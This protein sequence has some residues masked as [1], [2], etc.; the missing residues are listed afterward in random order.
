MLRT[1]LAEY[2]LVLAICCFGLSLRGLYLW[3]FHDSYIAGGMTVTLGE[4]ARLSLEGHGF[5]LDE[6]FTHCVNELQNKQMR[7]I[8][9]QE[10]LG[11]C[12]RSSELHPQALAMPGVAMLLH[13]IWWVT[14]D[15]RYLYLQFIQ[16]G[17]DI[18]NLVLVF[19]LGRTLFDSRTGSIGALLYASYPTVI[20]YSVAVLEVVWLIGGVLLIIL[21]AENLKREK[22]LWPS[23]A[24]IG[25]VAGV[26]A[27]IR[28]NMVLLPLAV[29]LAMLSQTHW[30]R[31]LT[32]ALVGVG[33]AYLCFSP[34]VIHGYSVF[35]RVMLAGRV[36][37]GQL[38][39]Q[40][41]GERPNPYGAVANDAITY[42][43]VRDMGYD[44]RYH[45]PEYDDILLERFRTILRDDPRF[46]VE[47]LM[48]RTLRIWRLPSAPWFLGVTQAWEEH[49]EAGGGYWGFAQA[50]P[51]YTF[52]LAIN[53]VFPTAINLLT[54]GGIWFSY[55]AMRGRLILLTIAAVWC[56]VHLP[57]LYVDRVIL[58]GILPMHLFFASFCIATLARLPWVKHLQERLSSI[59][60]R[61]EV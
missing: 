25:V 5:V 37:V 6:Q 3:Q 26:L 57:F 21:L 12:P 14:G 60:N 47:V 59:R 36:G 55:R 17:V 22:Q 51:L 42:Q 9:I 40:G 13:G 10:A 52:A 56:L 32:V 11:E 24:A 44:V 16:V 39:W 53:K 23:L 30:R 35:G 38:L 46:V 33:I 18:L 15:Y 1:T 2:W 45:S 29:G 4:M 48:M 19:V 7:L 8:D 50:N 43:Q 54:L 58:P 49:K 28:S 41:L 34:W 27:Y 20:T 61:L 31:A